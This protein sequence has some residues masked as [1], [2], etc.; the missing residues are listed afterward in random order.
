MVVKSAMFSWISGDES[1]RKHPEVFET[2]AEGLKS[3][4]KQKDPSIG[5]AV[6]F[7]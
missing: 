7:P 5:T 3:V 1:R 4:Y 6:F 2:V